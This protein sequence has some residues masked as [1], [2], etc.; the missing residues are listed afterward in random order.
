MNADELTE[1]ESNVLDDLVHDTAAAQAANAIASGEQMDWLVLMTGR[2]PE[3]ILEEVERR[4]CMD[5][6]T[7]HVYQVEVFTQKVGHD[8]FRGDLA[9]IAAAIS[10]GND[11]GDVRH[12]SEEPVPFSELRRHLIRIG[13]DGEFFAPA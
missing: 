2:S 3:D 13:N 11:V 5:E 6:V 9:E 4:A 8:P 7:R 1:D 12:V 10:D